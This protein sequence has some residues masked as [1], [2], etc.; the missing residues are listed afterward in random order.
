MW[1]GQLHL[2]V[3][4]GPL[5]FIYRYCRFDMLVA[6]TQPCHPDLLSNVFTSLL[7]LF[8]GAQGPDEPI[9][10]YQSWFDGLILERLWC[11]VAIPQM[12]LVK[13]FLRAL[14]NRYSDLLD[15]FLTHFKTIDSAIINSIVEDVEY[16][17]GFILHDWKVAKS[18]GSNA[19]VPAA[20]AA[21]MDQQGTVWINLYKW[22]SKGLSRSGGQGPL[23][24]QASAPFAITNISLGIS[25]QNALFLQISTLHL[26]KVLP[27]LHLQHLLLCHLPYLQVLLPMVAL[28]VLT[29]L[30]LVFPWGLHPR[31]LAYWYPRLKICRWSMNMILMTA[32]GGWG[33]RMCMC[34]CLCNWDIGLRW[35]FAILE[36]TNFHCTCRLLLV[37][38]LLELKCSETPQKGPSPTHQ[39]TP[40]PKD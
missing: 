39:C 15:Q 24:A 35:L 33:M 25:P 5:C 17:D 20:S 34:V 19:K 30:W 16:H 27:H 18:S 11:K 37:V 31:L 13:L 3:K 22:L 29:N 1:E 7:S 4:D 2:A 38:C 8:N 9:V 28:P 14:H 10:Q 32:I 36:D 40:S 12:L 21:N 26:N 6:L 23:L